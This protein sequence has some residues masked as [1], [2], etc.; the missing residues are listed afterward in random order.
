MKWIDLSAVLLLNALCMYQD[1]SFLHFVY[2]HFFVFLLFFSF[3][4]I[5]I[6]SLILQQIL[7]CFYE[8]Q[9]LLDDTV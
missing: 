1:I 2:L 7:D 6:F 4:F 9:Q 8:G 5:K 3:A